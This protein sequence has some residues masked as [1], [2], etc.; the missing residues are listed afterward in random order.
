MLRSR[1]QDGRST[2]YFELA[3]PLRSEDVG[4]FDEAWLRAIRVAGNTAL[5][6]DVS[7][8]TG[9]DGA[10]RRLLRRYHSRGIRFIASSERAR[11]LAESTAGIPVASVPV[12]CE[13]CGVWVSLDASQDR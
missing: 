8:L 10:G 5:V 13:P 3:G 11:T 7:L 6:I 1:L 9:I 12:V 4:K 2:L